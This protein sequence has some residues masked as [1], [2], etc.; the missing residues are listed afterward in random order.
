MLPE[1][2]IDLLRSQHGVLADH[3]LV[4]RLDPPDR[5]RVFQH[6]ELERLTA[7]VRRHRVTPVTAVQA[8]M[9]AVLDHG[10]HAMLWGKSAAAHWGFGPFR[11]TPVH[12]AVPRP[13][14]SRPAGLGQRHVLGSIGEADRTTFDG[15]PIS[16][17]ELTLLWIAGALTHR[18]GHERAAAKF[19]PIL[20][21][22]WRRRL[23]DGCWLHALAERAGG[24]GRSGIVV[25]RQ[26]LEQ[27]PPSYRP[28]GSRL[29]ERFESIL[30]ERVRVDLARQ[31]TVGVEPVVRTVDYR[32]RRWPLVAEPWAGAD[33]IGRG[34]RGCS[35]LAAGCVVEGPCLL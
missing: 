21:D 30:P 31:V 33:G 15:I 7:R 22:A 32:C 26:A 27:R 19:E 23:V 14:R 10:R 11:I 8:A 29:E 5:R 18:F 9:A 13:H 12:V 16:R 1:S 20:D 35:S 17:P 24:R 4:D 3:Q 34:A 25:L 28:A 2:V 6:P